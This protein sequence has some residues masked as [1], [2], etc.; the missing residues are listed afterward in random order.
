MI[1]SLG[2]AVPVVW[3][4]WLV[5]TDWVPMFPLNDLRR[6]NVHDRRL[7]AAI[8]YPFPLAVA[9]GVALHRPWSLA[10]SLALCALMV[11]GHVRSWWVP[12]FGSASDAQRERY[13]RDYARTV[14]LLPT[15]GRAVVIDVQHMV[16]GLL[17]VAMA[18][19]TIL[20]T[21]A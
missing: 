6:D 9:A 19:T 7:A 16:V 10:V 18:G 15:A 14:K 5:V 1:I 3:L 12:Y 13:R 2:V 21:I 20:A 4:L 8:N 17:T 11:L